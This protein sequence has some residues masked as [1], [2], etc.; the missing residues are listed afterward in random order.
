MIYSIY[1]TILFDI[2]ITIYHLVRNGVG[3]GKKGSGRNRV[4][5]FLRNRRVIS[6]VKKKKIAQSCC[7]GEYKLQ[8]F[9]AVFYTFFCYVLKYSTV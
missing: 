2:Y 9:T 3:T 1:G 5:N 7:T 6:G 8:R 4:T